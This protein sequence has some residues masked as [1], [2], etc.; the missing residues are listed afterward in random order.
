MSPHYRPPAP[1]TDG[2]AGGTARLSFNIGAT[3]HS[4][5]AVALPTARHATL[6]RVGGS[7][8]GAGAIARRNQSKCSFGLTPLIWYYGTIK[9]RFFGLKNQKQ[10]CSSILKLRTKF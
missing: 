10:I 7:A 6:A 8:S 9:N 4:E 2:S 3:V 1:A 5:Q